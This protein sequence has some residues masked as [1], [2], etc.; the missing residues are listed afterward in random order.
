M[1]KQQKIITIGIWAILVVAMVGFVAS[2]MWSRM[3]GSRTHG[4]E[5]I[6]LPKFQ[7]MAAF[8]LVNQAGQPFTSADLAGKVWIGC[9][10]FTRCTGPC[11]MMTANMAA[12]QRQL[13][14]TSVRLLSFSVDPEND[15]PPVL[16]EYARKYGADS[17]RW[18]F[19]TGARQDIYGI[20]A[21]IKIAV[22]PAEG[23]RPILHST[24]FILIDGSGTIRGYYD[25]TDPDAR[26]QLVQHA[27]S[28]AA[29]P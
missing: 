17:N 11:P 2:G 6:E 22:M 10:F 25:G 24:K 23:E 5:E 9:F 7:P 18:T 1:S 29:G 26:A 19:L 28:L 20:A 27:K 15:T 8:A 3:L 21:A 13:A 12:M 14:D 16:A 4:I